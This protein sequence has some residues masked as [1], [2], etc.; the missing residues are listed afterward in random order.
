M[1]LTAIPPHGPAV[2]PQA[3]RREVV[4][5][6][7]GQGDQAHTPACGEEGCEVYS[8]LTVDSDSDDIVVGISHSLFTAIQQ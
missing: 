2:R 8:L 7:H 1:S 5:R 4:C 6:L 3:P